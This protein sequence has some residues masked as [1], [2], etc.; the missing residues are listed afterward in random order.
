M[1]ELVYITFC[2]CSGAY[3]AEFHSTININI[4][5]HYIYSVT[6]CQF[7]VHSL[8]VSVIVRFSLSSIE[9]LWFSHFT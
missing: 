6:H 5:I 7:S 4:I 1:F 2:T 3:Q 8:L 9:Q